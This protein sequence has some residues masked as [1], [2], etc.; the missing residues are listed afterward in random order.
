ME[1][2]MQR[3]VCNDRADP[4]DRGREMDGE[5]ELEEP[6][7]MVMSV[8]RRLRPVCYERCLRL[9]GGLSNSSVMS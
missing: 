4:A 5:H 6:G 8:S 1:K 9:R 7:A 2:R 3:Q